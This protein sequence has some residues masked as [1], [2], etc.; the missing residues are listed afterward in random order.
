MGRELTTIEE[1]SLNPKVAAQMMRN[2][3][4]NARN[5]ADQLRTAYRTIE[6]LRGIV[7]EL[8]KTCAEVTV[9]VQV[10]RSDDDTCG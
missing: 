5:L 8:E 7:R 3:Q 4:R 10:L 6:E 2:L 9:K 1:W